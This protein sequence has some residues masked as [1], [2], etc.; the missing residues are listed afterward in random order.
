MSAPALSISRPRQIA[1]K[2]FG[3]IQVDAEN[4]VRTDEGLFG[5]PACREWV[6]LEGARR[7]TAWLQSAEHPELAFLLA[8]PFTAVEGY[9][10]DL[11]TR[12]LDMIG[13]TEASD[14]AVFAIVTVADRKGDCPTANL[15]A[16]IVLDVGGRRAAQVI[17]SDGRWSV[18]APLSEQ[19]LG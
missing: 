14:V 10:V 4:L 5:F 17:I 18:K 9:A 13:A 7:S 1:T 19:V 15:A 11:A 6:L 8:D 3:N 2:L 16:P 12:E